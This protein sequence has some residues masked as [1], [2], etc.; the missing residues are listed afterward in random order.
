M[1]AN[2]RY[3]RKGISPDASTY[4]SPCVRSNQDL[5]SQIVPHLQAQNNKNIE[6]SINNFT[7]SSKV[8]LR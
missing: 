2:R 1:H 4:I 3:M 8:G 6:K 5:V 7:S